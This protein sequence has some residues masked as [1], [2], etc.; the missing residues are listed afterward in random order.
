MI[1]LITDSAADLPKEMREDYNIKM[2]PINITMGNQTYRDQIDLSTD[3]FYEKLLRTKEMPSTAYPG[4]GLIIETFK[5]AVEAGN[6]VIFICLSGALSGLYNAA[7]LAKSEFPNAEIAVIDSK[8][9]TFGQGVIV[10]AAAR[11]IKQGKSYA[12]VVN[13]CEDFVKRSCGFGVVSNLE[14]LHRGGRLSLATTLAATALNIKP[15][16]EIAADGSLFMVHKTRGIIK[17]RHW[18][19]E[20]MKKDGKNYK[21]SLVWVAYI[22][23]KEQALEF[24]KELAQEVELGEVLFG[25]VSATIGTHL[26]PGLVGIFYLAPEKPKK[27]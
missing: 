13:A 18:L 23:E 10:L 4:L 21:D 26:G 9:A 20:H 27:R 1:T 11:L 22:R 12:E 24:K 6:S 3:E 2:L 25:E 15:V 8:S 16:I 17:G 19:I 14:Y 5:E 7:L